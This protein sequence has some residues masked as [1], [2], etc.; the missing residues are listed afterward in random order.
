MCPYKI[1]D[2][3][4]MAKKLWDKGYEINDVLEAYTTG[5]DWRL[6][7]AL[8]K[9][10]C[11][12]SM[13]H[14]TMLA[15]AGILE[16]SELGPL[17]AELVKIVGDSE[18]GEF[19]IAPADEDVHTAVEG[20]LV[21]RLGDLGKKVHTCRS[22]NDQ[23]IVDLRLYGKA[24]LLLLID[25]MLEYARTLRT[26][27][28]KHKGVPMVGR[29]HMQR[30]MPMSVGLWAA[31][32]LESILDD[33]ELLQ[34]VFALNDQC[35]LGSAASFGVPV[36]I[37]RQLTSDLLGFAKVQNNVLYANNSRGKIEGLLLAA[38]S[39]VMLDLSKLAQDLMLYSMPEF[40]YFLVPK[41]MCTGS[42][43]MPQKRNPCGCELVRA[44]T[45]S[46]LACHQEVMAIATAIPSGYNRDNQQTKGP[47]MRGLDLT[48][49]SVRVLN[50]TISKL[51]VNE[52]KCRAGFHP[53]V[54][55]VD[56]ALEMVAGGMPFRDA[57]KHVGTHLEELESIDPDYGI[58][59]RTHTGS[60]G[61]LALDQSDGRIEAGANF[62]AER[63]ERFEQAISALGF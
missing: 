20:R 35:P 26:F 32:Q 62:T 27:A 8:I 61:N 2:G 14:A 15:K 56:K 47:F 19:V 22:R 28:E 46:V 16:D 5:D 60:A 50:L 48:L 13:A 11:V 39:Q 58:T 45:A 49:T 42:S 12:G 53:E 23:V 59:S 54:F 41:E 36:E 24:Q 57:Y 9:W 30:A 38:C 63:G 31:A 33:V 29:T 1:A 18:S 43:I 3:K 4:I 51:E 34:T 55:A 40:G 21:E 17:R 7:A 52:D 44:K 25:A 10:D 37:D 6:D